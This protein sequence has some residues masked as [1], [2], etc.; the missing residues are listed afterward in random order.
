MAP[1]RGNGTDLDHLL[2][3]GAGEGLGGDMAKSVDDMADVPAKRTKN[4]PRGRD[5]EATEGRILDATWR[6]FEREGP[7]AGINLQEVADEAGINRSLVYQYF[8]T[9][10]EVVRRALARRLSLAQS[11]FVAGFRLP[12][13]KRRLRAFKVI[14]KDA[15][16]SKL[17][18]QLVLADEPAVRILPMLADA[19]HALAR[20]VADGSVGPDADIEVMHAMTAIVNIAYAVFRQNVAGELGMNEAELDRRAAKVFAQMLDGLTG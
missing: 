12:F 17:M 5:R 14:A 7:L 1:D 3:R 6:I 2:P 10:D 9:R 20:D 15:L 19:R 4:Q 11:A 13:A 16:P 8:G 18:T